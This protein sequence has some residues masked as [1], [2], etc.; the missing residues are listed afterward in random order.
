[1]YKVVWKTSLRDLRPKL[2]NVFYVVA[3]LITLIAVGGFGYLRWWIILDS[4]WLITI[5]LRIMGK[6]NMVPGRFTV[7]LLLMLLFILEIQYCNTHSKRSALSSC[8]LRVVYRCWLCRSKR[9]SVFCQA[10][11]VSGRYRCTNC[12]P[13]RQQ[14]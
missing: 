7:W 2:R 6:T 4:H 3:I 8:W 10:A 9:R 12:L 5:I 11:K 1:L 14:Q 13:T